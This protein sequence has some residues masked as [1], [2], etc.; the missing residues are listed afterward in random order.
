[1]DKEQR[2][3]NLKNY[4]NRISLSAQFI[5][6]LST[7]DKLQ[8]AKL[9]IVYNT[10]SSLVHKSIHLSEKVSIFTVKWIRFYTFLLACVFI[11]VCV[12]AHLSVS[13]CLFVHMNLCM[14]CVRFVFACKYISFEN[15]CIYICTHVCVS[16]C[17]CMHICIYLCILYFYSSEKVSLSVLMLALTKTSQYT[18]KTRF[19]RHPL[20]TKL[21]ISGLQN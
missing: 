10:F 11:C 19:I 21:T 3:Y 5:G 17:V 9:R 2:K 15:A 6:I 1:M 18:H 7:Q 20:R 16:M 4:E 8:T 12:C 14:I 13:V